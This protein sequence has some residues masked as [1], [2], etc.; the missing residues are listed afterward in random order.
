VS[1]TVSYVHRPIG[2]QDNPDCPH[3]KG[4]GCGHVSGKCKMCA[5]WRQ[6]TGSSECGACCGTGKVLS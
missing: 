3:C 6:R 5:A 1:K 2:R 4:S